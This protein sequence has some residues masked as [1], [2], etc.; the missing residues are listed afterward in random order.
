MNLI[1]KTSETVALELYL[2]RSW[3]KHKINRDVSDFPGQFRCELPCSF[4]GFSWASTGI[5]HRE[6]SFAQGLL[7]IV[8]YQRSLGG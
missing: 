8:E 2:L 4:T 7:N 5:V 1:M 3:A 6:M